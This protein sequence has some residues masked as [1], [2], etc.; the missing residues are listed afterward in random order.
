MTTM[1]ESTSYRP[2]IRSFES[3]LWEIRNDTGITFQELADR[4]GVSPAYI[5]QILKRGPTLEQVEKIAKA[6]DVQIIHDGQHLFRFGLIRKA[7]LDSQM[8]MC[9]QCGNRRAHHLI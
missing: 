9:I 7:D 6:L 1:P 3:Q 8:P 4:I 5:S 2:A